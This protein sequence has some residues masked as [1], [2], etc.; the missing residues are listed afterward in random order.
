MAR[1]GED[2]KL[3]AMLA[4]ER[5]LGETPFSRDKINAPLAAEDSIRE[6]PVN[7]GS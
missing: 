1:N 4:V 3:D 7:L 5:A 2:E 6:T